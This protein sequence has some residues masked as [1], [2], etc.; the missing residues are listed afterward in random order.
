[1]MR[2]STR[3][4]GAMLCVVS[5]MCAAP[6][7]A[8][9][10]DKVIVVVNNEVVTQREVERVMSS[11]YEQYRSLYFGDELVKKI[12]EA[13]QRILEQI[14]ED[15]LV[16]SEAKR[17]KV[18]VDEKD[19]D[20][21]VGDIITRFPSKEDFEKALVQ[22]GT[23]LKEMKNR[24]KDQLQVRKLIEQ[25][26]GS[27]IAISPME[28]TEYYTKHLNEFSIP[29]EIE[30]RNIL[31]KPR[32]GLPPDKAYLQAKELL[33]RIREG[34]DFAGLAR[35]Y[36]S[37]PY[38]KDGGLMGSVKRGDLLPEIDKVVF[39]MKEA[40]VSEVVQTSVGY[41]IFMVEKRRE[42][43][44]LGLSEVKREVEE[45]IYK[46]KVRDKLKG[47]IATLKKNAYIAYK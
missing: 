46:E 34:C 39:T 47:W 8:E 20:S 40:E 15:R 44:I 36:S 42:Q 1:M 11:V 35:E 18:E 25:K 24:F 43:R 27:K 33:Q 2:F 10:V 32:E 13:R 26:I 17:Q 4:Y 21:Q 29:D 7:A 37:G 19:I 22:Q 6:V 45:R 28:I 3:C 31:I 14:I 38:A 30:L 23:T 5:A 16:L 9:V 12:D 41:H